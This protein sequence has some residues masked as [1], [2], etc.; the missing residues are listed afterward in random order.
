MRV[1]LARL[2]PDKCSAE[3]VSNILNESW[4]SLICDECNKECNVLL[5]IGQPEDY[6]NRWWDMCHDCLSSGMKMMEGVA[7]QDRERFSAALELARLVSCSWVD[8]PDKWKELAARA[9]GEG[10]P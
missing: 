1:A 8:I 9:I 3:D 2:D 6:D 4:V 10:T 5:H 7:K